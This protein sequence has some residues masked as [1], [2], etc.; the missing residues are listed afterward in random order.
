MTVHDFAIV[1]TPPIN[2]LAII[3]ACAAEIERIFRGAPSQHEWP[4][5]L[6]LFCR[7]ELYWADDNTDDTFRVRS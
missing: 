3:S 7:H 5:S 6:R 2:I 1:A 4:L